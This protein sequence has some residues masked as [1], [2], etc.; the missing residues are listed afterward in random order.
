VDAAGD[1]AM[2]EKTAREAL[3]GAWVAARLLG[4]T[5]GRSKVVNTL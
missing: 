3:L 4:R 5:R 1:A 2:R